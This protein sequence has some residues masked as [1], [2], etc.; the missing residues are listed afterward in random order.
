MLGTTFSH[1]K[2]LEKLGGGGMGVV[3]KAEDTKLKRFVALK[4]LPP[5]LTA[6]KD[7]EERF[8]R[9]AQAASALQ[10][11]NICTV[12]DID[13]TDDGQIFMVM[14]LYEGETLKKKIADGPM[15]PDDVARIAVQI[16]EGLARAHG[17]EIVHRDIKPANIL[18]TNDGVVKIL[19]FGLAKFLRSPFVTREGRRAGTTLYMSPEQLRGEAI[20]ARTDIWSFGI[21]LY[22]MLTGVHPF[23]AEFDESVMYRIMTDEP[24]P[25]STVQPGVPKALSDLV[26]HCLEREKAKRPQSMDEIL[27]TL[28]GHADAHQSLTSIRRKGRVIAFAACVVVAAGLG[29]YLARDLFFPPVPKNVRLAVLLFVDETKDTAIHAFKPEIQRLFVSEFMGVHHIT[30]EDRLHLNASVVQQFAQDNPPRTDELFRFL[31][32]HEYEYVVDGSITSSP[33]GGVT[34]EANLLKGNDYQRVEVFPGHLQSGAQLE[35]VVQTLSR[36]VLAYLRTKVLDIKPEMGIWNRNRPN[37][38]AAVA[39]LDDAYNFYCLGDRRAANSALR[40][41]VQI[42][43][44]FVSPRIWLA[45]YYKRYDPEEGKKN[46][47]YL[48]SVRSSVDDFG[49]AMIDWTEAF[50][51]DSYGDQIRCLQ[52]ALT[53]DPGNR[54]LLENL[55]ATYEEMHD[56]VNVLAAYKYC[57]D[58]HWEYQP[59]YARAVKYYLDERNYEAAKEALLVWK[60]LD[61][62]SVSPL[63]CGWLNAIALRTGDKVEAERWKNRFVFLCIDSSISRTEFILGSCY[64]DAGLIP[65]G[66]SLI[67]S[68]VALEKTN[69]EYRHKLGVALLAS[70]DTV[71][72][73]RELEVAAQLNP[74]AKAIALTLGNISREKGDSS[75]AMEHYQK[76]LLR[77]STGYDAQQIRKWVRTLHQ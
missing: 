15:P 23:D 12:H 44:T 66:C 37:N 46:L 13:E 2:I 30:V 21:L 50:F 75:A 43:S 22:Q 39:R 14:D 9:E 25:V 41:A 4:F 42:D 59:L 69:A 11:N 32:Q 54:V 53:F 35:A 1:Y 29:L 48:Q 16:A 73:V 40:E 10:H 63:I 26:M 3:Y 71:S 18:V 6:D 24:V 51:Q 56:T 49:R 58:T 7:A 67:R 52:K 77:D 74:R 33:A 28:G 5:E 20:D 72:G 8:I 17:K 70:G 27:L 60:G 62:V 55:G 19:D 61:T 36:Q 64:V 65:E 47:L 68:A 31:R 45:S 76:Y 57:I 34:I 38:W